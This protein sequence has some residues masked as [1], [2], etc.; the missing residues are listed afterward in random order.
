[1]RQQA[2]SKPTEPPEQMQMEEPS[3]GGSQNLRSILYQDIFTIKGKIT[4]IQTNF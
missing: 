3:S 1:M 4:K 2:A